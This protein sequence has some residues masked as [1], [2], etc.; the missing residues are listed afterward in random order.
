MTVVVISKEPWNIITHKN[1]GN[2]SLTNG[3]YT[4][5]VGSNTFN[6]SRETHYIRIME[7]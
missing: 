7:S 4:I 5:T 3:I 2:I 6:Y 1:V